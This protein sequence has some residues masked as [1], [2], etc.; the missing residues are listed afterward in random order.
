M[1][2][3]FT[4]PTPV[5]MTPPLNIVQSLDGMRSDL[6]AYDTFE[7]SGIRSMNSFPISCRL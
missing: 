2:H 6:N 4:K 5:Q 3:W 1:E 7:D